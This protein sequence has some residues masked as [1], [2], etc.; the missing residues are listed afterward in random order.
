MLI[1]GFSAQRCHS[2]YMSSP[3]S[4]S[5]KMSIA[6][7]PYRNLLCCVLWCQAFIPNN[8][9]TLPPNAAHHSKEDSGTRHFDRLAFH[10]SMPYTMNVTILMAAR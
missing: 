8:A 1:E 9:P 2:R 6:G 4:M 10:L 7:T 5:C 3:I